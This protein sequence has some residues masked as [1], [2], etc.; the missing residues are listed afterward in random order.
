MDQ[1]NYSI[2][3]FNAYPDEELLNVLK[4]FATANKLTHVS[5]REFS[6]SRFEFH[7]L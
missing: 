5:S 1:A 4:R 2:K 7:G 3:R 6:K